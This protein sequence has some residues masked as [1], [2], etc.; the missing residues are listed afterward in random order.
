[1]SSA[2]DAAQVA[3]YSRF[4][5]QWAGA[6]PIQFPGAVFTPPNEAPWVRV[7]LIWGDAFEDTMEPTA[8]NT[9]VAVIHVTVFGPK[10]VGRKDVMAKVNAVRDIFN[11]VEF[12]GVR[13]GAP[14]GPKPVEDPEWE[15]LAVTIPCTIDELT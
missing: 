3:V 9:L 12:S 1:M 4:N 7:E 6:T 5:T 14:S 11:R 8:R 2:L 15:A 13:C 10:A